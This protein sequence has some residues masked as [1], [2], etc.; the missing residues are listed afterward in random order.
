MAVVAPK[1]SLGDVIGIICPSRVPDPARHKRSIAVLSSLGFWVKLGGNMYKDAYGYATSTEECA[2]YLNAMVSGGDRYFLRVIKPALFDT[3]IKGVDIQAFLHDKGFPVPALIRT[4]NNTLHVQTENAL[5][6]LYE[7]IEGV[8][9]D[10]EQDAEAIGAF[11]GRLHRIMRDYTGELV[12]RDK[13]FLIG[14]YI[15]ILRKKQYPTADEFQAYGDAVWDRIKDLPHGYCHGD[16]YSGNIHKAPDCKLYLLD[17]DTSCESFPMYDPTLICNQTHYFDFDES[18][19]GKSKE[20]LIRF[21]PGYLKHN[22]LCETEMNAFFD[23]IAL[24]HFAL[25]ATIIEMYGLDCVDNAFLDKQ[26]DWLYRWREQCESEA[27][28]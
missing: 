4:K 24:Y 15:D 16:M 7:F 10:P 8:E 28:I 26:L 21:R 19:Y 9:S 11:V 2:A 6:I 17:F 18:G 27:V 22:T 5:Y 12:K 23:L 20:A 1:L 14:R 25:Q 3:A 13:Y